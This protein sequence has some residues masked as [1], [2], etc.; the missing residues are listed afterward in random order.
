MCTVRGEAV[1]RAGR[2]RPAARLPATSFR[3]ERESRGN[4]LFRDFFDGGDNFGFGYADEQ[5]FTGGGNEFGKR[6]GAHFIYFVLRLRE[7]VK[8]AAGA[9]F[10]KA[11]RFELFVRVFDGDDAYARFEADFANGWQAKIGREF[12]RRNLLFYLIVNLLAGGNAPRS[13]DGQSHRLTFSNLFCAAFT[14]STES[15]A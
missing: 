9:A 10:D 2:P 8:P 6:F 13:K 1:G 5:A 11:G 4:G 15:P 3:T 14:P 12:S 7:D